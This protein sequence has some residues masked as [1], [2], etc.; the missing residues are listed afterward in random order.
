MSYKNMMLRTLK[1][2]LS[3]A[4]EKGEASESNVK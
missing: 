1:S 4:T 2:S 3:D